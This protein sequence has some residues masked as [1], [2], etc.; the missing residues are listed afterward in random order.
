[1]KNL[2]IFLGSSL[3]T[4]LFFLSVVVLGFFVLLPSPIIKEKER[5]KILSFFS[6]SNVY[7]CKALC[8][9][10]YEALGLENLPKKPCVVFLKHASVYEMFFAVSLLQPSSYVAKYE[11]MF[12][13]ILRGALKALKCIPV[14]RGLGK[15]EVSKV[16]EQ[17]ER[18]LKDGRWIV[19]CPE[20]TRVPYGETRRY[21]LSG[22]LLAKAVGADVLPIAHNAG[23]FWGRRSLI[24]KPG[25]I[26]FS[27]GRPIET[28]NKNAQE[29]NQAAQSW[30][31]EEISKMTT[32]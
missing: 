24:K 7:A 6:R 25:L 12:V 8:G 17:G 1:M 13:P 31:E 15:A 10:H 23:Y 5:W 3:Y 28:K 30:I 22:S 16:L 21:G 2:L 18:C 11:L 32:K 20:G 26:T 4:L 19:I 27:V 9:L 29:I 14:K